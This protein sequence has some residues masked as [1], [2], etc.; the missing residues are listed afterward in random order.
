MSLCNSLHDYLAPWTVRV[1]Q[2]ESLI[3]ALG[4]F[5][6]LTKEATDD[7]NE[8]PNE[9]DT[10]YVVED[11][12]SVVQDQRFRVFRVCDLVWFA[13]PDPVEGL[14]DEKLN[15]PLTAFALPD[16]VPMVEEGALSPTEVEDL[17]LGL[18]TASKAVVIVAAAELQCVLVSSHLAPGLPLNVKAINGTRPRKLECHGGNLSPHC[19]VYSPSA[20]GS[21]D[22]IDCSSSS[23]NSRCRVSF[24]RRC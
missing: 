19:A 24:L 9:F 3:G 11:D 4:K 6:D 22:E 1:T 16:P 7:Q 18:P 17:L 23:A 2:D 13:S 15:S 10:Y 21:S 8:K 5:L 14:S 12:S 20:F